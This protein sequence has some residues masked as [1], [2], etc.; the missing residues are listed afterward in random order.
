M[1]KSTVTGVLGLLIGLLIGSFFLT[2]DHKNDA[3]GDA[4]TSAQTGGTQDAE[5]RWKM[6]SS[7]A[8]TLIVAGTSGKYVE[9]RVRTLS[10]GNMELRYFDPVLWFR[11]WKFLTL[12]QRARLMQG[13]QILGFGLEKSRHFNF[14]QQCR[15]DPARAR[16]WLGCT[17]AE[18]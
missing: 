16:L 9:E 3:P 8:S 12:Y 10:D 14:L 6:A 11:L 17:T 7:F 18:A 15:L 13:G 1:N 4:A 5:V 2:T